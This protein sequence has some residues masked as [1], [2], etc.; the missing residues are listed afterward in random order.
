MLITE[1]RMRGGM[2]F[3][4]VGFLSKE[5]SM[6]TPLAAAVDCKNLRRVDILN[7]GY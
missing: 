4:V 1:K 6:N 7:D 3:S 5:E 2:A